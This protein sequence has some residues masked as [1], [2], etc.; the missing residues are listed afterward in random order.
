[1]HPS[2]PGAWSGRLSVELWFSSNN[3]STHQRENNKQSGNQ[4]KKR[5]EARSKISSVFSH[6]SALLYV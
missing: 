1:M 6:L 2:V 5:Q 4:I 3:E